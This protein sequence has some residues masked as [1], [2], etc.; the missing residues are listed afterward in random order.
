MAK[1]SFTAARVA[2][3]E[4]ETGKRQTIHWDT[5]TPGL[6]L[7][8]TSGSR[9]YI[10][11]SRL[12]GRTLRITI[13]AAHAW[14]LKKAR[15]EAARLRVL[16][17]AGT[18]PR[19]QEAKERAAAEAK[20]K[21]ARRND[22][23][24]REAWAV[25]LEHLRSAISPKTKKPRSA[26][27]LADHEAL[28]APGGQPRKR[29]KKDAITVAGPLASLLDLRLAELVAPRVAAWLEVETAQ[30]PTNAAH[31]YRLLKAFIRWTTN[32]DDYAGIVGADAWQ[33]PKVT[34]LVP[35]SKAKPGGSLQ[36]EQLQAWFKAVKALDNPVA[37]AYLQATLICGA[38]REEMAA[39]RWDDVD[40]RWGGL[41][42]RDKVDTLNGR[43][44]PL[45]PYLAAC[46]PRCPVATNGSSAASGQKTARLPSHAFPITGR[47]R[48]RVCRT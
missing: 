42:L 35:Q 32:H 36:R 28:A 5:D 12:H 33:S 43:D 11:E 31:A 48:W 1:V 7:R 44:I 29:G 3:F 9:A 26:R 46:W 17:D 13:G 22:V 37:S 16:V 30:R 14:P 8:V 2:A 20:R 21:A 41:H 19:E 40:F 34:G 45:P 27:Y 39:L 38:R 24:V 23:T 6:G 10:Y 4:C 18:D 25:Y 15:V 47:W